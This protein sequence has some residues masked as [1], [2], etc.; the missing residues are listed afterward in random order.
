MLWVKDDSKIHSV[1]AGNKFRKLAHILREAE[2]HDKTRIVTFG[3]AGSHH[4]LATARLAKVRGFSVQAM[5]ISQPWSAHA[6]QVLR[7]SVA[8]G[9]ELVPAMSGV[10]ALRAAV[11]M[12]D[13]QSTLVPPGGSNVC[14]SLGYFEAA[15]ELAR[16]VQQ[17]ELPEPDCI[18]LAFGTGGTAA[19]L[20][21]GAAYAGLKSTIVGVSVLRAPGRALYAC[22]LANAILRSIGSNSSVKQDRLV[23]DSRWI[24]AGYGFET[25]SGTAATLRAASLDLPLDPSY[26]AKAFAGALALVEGTKS[27]IGDNRPLKMP[28]PSSHVLYWHTL[29]APC[30][31]QLNAPNVTMLPRSLRALLRPCVRADSS[32]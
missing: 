10:S 5:V 25:A 18:V 30:S 13:A 31:L 15:V 8:S 12:M 26:T 16:Q 1:Y 7:A 28:L 9:A 6:E 17:G 29:S 2:R 3:T 11:Q 14:G 21:A 20:L 22:K 27:P 19:G 32:N 4:V 23:I 24:G